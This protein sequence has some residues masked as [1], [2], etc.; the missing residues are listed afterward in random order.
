MA[1]ISVRSGW[2]AYTKLMTGEAADARNDAILHN[3]RL[4]HR[5]ECLAD[6]RIFPTMVPEPEYRFYGAAGNIQLHG[7]D[8]VQAFYEGNWAARSSLV[9][10]HVE[11][12]AFGDWGAAAAGFM[13]QQ[14]P[15]ES[16]GFFP[17]DDATPVDE[18]DWYLLETHLSWFFPYEEIGGEVRLGG[19]VCYVDAAGTTRTPVAPADVLSM[20]EAVEQFADTMHL[21]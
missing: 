6:R 4:H 20:A 18:A 5:Y 15:A 11:F 17:S 16:A 8:E 12:V 9:E 1:K 19:E 10:L 13:R 14:V 21:T 2:D 7:M 3:M